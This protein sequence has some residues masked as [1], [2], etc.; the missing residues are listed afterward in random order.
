MRGGRCANLDFAWLQKSGRALLVEF[1][2]VNMAD[3]DLTRL[4]CSQRF[5]PSR[6][7]IAWRPLRRDR[8]AAPVVWV[9]VR[10]GRWGQRV[11]AGNNVKAP[12]ERRLG[13]ASL[14]CLLF[15]VAAKP[16]T[17]LSPQGERSCH[18]WKSPCLCSPCQTRLKS[19]APR[20]AVGRRWWWKSSLALV[21]LEV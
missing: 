14:G 20:A 5:P 10:A 3:I 1:G 4:F 9:Y 8:H 7:G 17:P 13:R 15:E 16:A 18:S 6:R 19:V 2:G 11:V 21:H 12:L